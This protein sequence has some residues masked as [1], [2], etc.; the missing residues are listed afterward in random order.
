[1]INPP[2]SGGFSSGGYMLSVMPKVYIVEQR[3]K[4]LRSVFGYKWE[5]VTD[6]D[7]CVFMDWKTAHQM[8]REIRLFD[9]K[10][11]EYRV[12]TK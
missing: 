8:M 5:P 2:P 11:F 10:T 1:V 4:T 6:D 9:G 7:A 3:A 12:T